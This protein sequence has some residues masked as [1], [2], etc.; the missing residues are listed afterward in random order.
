MK[1]RRLKRQILVGARRVRPDPLLEGETY[2]FRVNPRSLALAS[3]GEG[4]R[5]GGRERVRVGR[6]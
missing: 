3:E 2:F 1:K 5:A 6:E 4:G